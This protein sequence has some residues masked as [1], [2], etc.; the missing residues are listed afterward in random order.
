MWSA[1]SV[2]WWTNTCVHWEADRKI[3][4]TG[5]QALLVTRTWPVAEGYICVTNDFSPECFLTVRNFLYSELL[6]FSLENFYFPS[7][8]ISL[9]YYSQGWGP[10]FSYLNWP[11]LFVLNISS[12][13]IDQGVQRETRNKDIY[14]HEF[15]SGYSRTSLLVMFFYCIYARCSLDPR[16]FRCTW[17]SAHD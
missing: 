1:G 14:T 5:N 15:E 3:G 6:S 10:H 9:F 16:D 7:P 8:P 17:V 2:A 11:T 12:F 4:D 13:M